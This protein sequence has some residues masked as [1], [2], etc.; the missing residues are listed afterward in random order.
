MKSARSQQLAVI[1]PVLGKNEERL[2]KD[3]GQIKRGDGKTRWNSL[4]Y[5][6]SS[7]ISEAAVGAIS[8]RMPD[9][10]TGNERLI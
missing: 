2:E 5:I 9:V 8:N 6:P 10:K 1:N 3:T 7:L 4:P